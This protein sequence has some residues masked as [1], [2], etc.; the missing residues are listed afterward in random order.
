M[1]TSGEDSKSG[2]AVQVLPLQ[3]HAPPPP[4]DTAVQ[5]APTLAQHIISRSIPVALGRCNILRVLCHCG[6]CAVAAPRASLQR[7]SFLQLPSPGAQGPHDHR[8][9]GLLAQPPMFRPPLAGFVTALTAFFNYLLHRH[10]LYFYHQARD[11]VAD[12]CSLQVLIKSSPVV[13]LNDAATRCCRRRRWN[14]R[15][16]C[17]GISSKQ[18]ACA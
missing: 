9:G 15:W 14:C 8:H 16:A 6:C 18:S 4:C 5:E 10:V 7:D 2:C 11:L 3:P 17:R 13:L 12:G 1:N